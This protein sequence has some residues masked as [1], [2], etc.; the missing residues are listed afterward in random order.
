[1]HL[2]LLITRSLQD[3]LEQLRSYQTKHERMHRLSEKLMSEQAG[4]AERIR[5]SVDFKSLLSARRQNKAS[6]MGTYITG[7]LSC[8][9]TCTV[10][11][12]MYRWGDSCH[13]GTVLHCLHSIYSELM[14]FY[15]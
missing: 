14:R 3:A 8:D 1:V 9:V 6:V 11:R 12:E 5:T 2:S 13:I 15:S 10:F 4:A 7:V